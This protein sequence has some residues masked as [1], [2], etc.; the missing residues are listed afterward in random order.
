[1][2]KVLFT[3]TSLHHFTLLA[4]LA[5]ALLMT[6]CG[7]KKLQTEKLRSI[8]RVAV[9]VLQAP[10]VPKWKDAQY[11]GE[12]DAVFNGWSPSLHVSALEALMD[13]LKQNTSF[14]WIPVSQVVEDEE[15][16]SLAKR[17]GGGV[18][19]GQQ[20]SP[21]GLNRN[22]PLTPGGYKALAKSLRADL[23]LSISL[24]VEV[25][26]FGPEFSL[27]HEVDGVAMVDATV[28]GYD[29][30][31]SRIWFERGISAAS[32]SFTTKGW[33]PVTD[34]YKPAIRQAFQAVGEKIA[35]RMTIPSSQ[36]QEDEEERPRPK[37]SKK[38]KR[39]EEE[40]DVD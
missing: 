1:M 30:S 24:T 8:D 39:V 34:Q 23:L 17:L 9:I 26:R 16:V 27:K 36:F 31:G 7:D 40:E 35:A 13:T 29:S 3:I 14:K 38:K 6:G 19:L 37:K 15:Y 4:W 10:Q 21:K 22:P 5:S 32:P 25:H 28:D 12:W 11:F 33:R 18:L 2:H 20:V